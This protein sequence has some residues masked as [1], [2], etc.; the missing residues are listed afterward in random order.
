M[1]DDAVHHVGDK[2][3]QE[4]EVRAPIVVDGLLAAPPDAAL[5]LLGSC[6]DGIAIPIHEALKA[7]WPRRAGTA[8]A[9]ECRAV[10]FSFVLATG[11]PRTEQQ[12]AALRVL[13]HRLTTLVAAMPQDVRTAVERSYP[14]GLGQPWWDW[15]SELEPRRWSLRR[16][17][18]VGSANK[19]GMRGE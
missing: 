13:L 11:S 14:G 5:A 2:L 15:V 17:S 8:T 16:R 3:G 7:R 12:R 19:P 6:S 9:D 18:G 1:S 10:A 4:F